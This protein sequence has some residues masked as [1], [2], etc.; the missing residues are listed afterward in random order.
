VEAELRPIVE[1]E[2]LSRSFG[3]VK[4]LDDVSFTVYAGQILALIGP[5]GAGKTTMLNIIAGT[6]APTAGQALFRGKRL[7]GRAA[8]ER[9]RLGMART[10][11]Q[12]LIF[13]TMSVLE[14]A[15]VG[16]H[17]RGHS[18]L[19]D[20]AF[21]LPRARREEED[22]TLEALRVL[23]LVGLGAKAQQEAAGLPF[24][25][26]RLLAIA[27]ALATSPEVLLL[28]EPAAGLNR[29]EKNDL[30]EL[31]QRIRALGMTVILVEHDMDLVMRLADWVVVLDH[32]KR[33]AQG[34]PEEV[35]RDA[36]V[37]EAYLGVAEERKP[38]A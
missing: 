32:G 6:L 34:R 20:A 13:Q 16:C 36:A 33:L 37:V 17:A 2:R 23:N 30:A 27:R 18:G 8:H 24:G 5:N 22:L 14:N 35:R 4:A 31:V 26:Q 15:L 10:F 11:Q 9:V 12:A 28:D 29:L 25:Q 3:G 21:A 38:D 1:I 7:A 19:L